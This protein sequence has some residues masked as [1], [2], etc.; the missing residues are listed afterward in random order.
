[1][2]TSLATFAAF[3]LSA[4]ALLADVVIVQKVETPGQ[5]GDMTLKVRDHR[6]R[7]DVTPEI[8]TIMDTRSGEI[9]T[10]MHAQKAYMNIPASMTRKILDAAK[11]QQP[12]AAT[13]A[14]PELKPT[15]QKETINGHETEIYTLEA[16]EM[17]S[18]FWIAKSY[19]NEKVVLE[20]FKRINESPM[21]KMAQEMARQPSD[22][23]GVPVKTEI[24]VGPDQKVTSTLISVEEKELPERE[25]T[26]PEGFTAIQMPAQQ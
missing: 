6:I 12:K 1:M 3:L 7:I 4:V 8:S 25:F 11:D 14:K 23:P 20:T 18:R 17:K 22:F 16:G 5:S 24:T 21:S 9:T 19:P 26:V 2:K 10:I 15:G 13:P